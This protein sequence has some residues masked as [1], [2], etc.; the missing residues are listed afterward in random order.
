MQLQWVATA[1][2]DRI[3]PITRP[4]EVL[5]FIADH[6]GCCAALMRTAKSN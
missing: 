3:S 1:E 4:E 6:P 5:R 2:K